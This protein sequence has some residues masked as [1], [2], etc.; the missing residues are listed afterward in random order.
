M[1]SQTDPRRNLQIKNQ[2]KG[3]I[4]CEIITYFSTKQ[5]P[6]NQCLLSSYYVPVPILGTGDI[7]VNQTDVPP[8]PSNK[9]SNL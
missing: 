9:E 7:K 8:L 4:I 2:H 6:L 3:L 5:L 1:N